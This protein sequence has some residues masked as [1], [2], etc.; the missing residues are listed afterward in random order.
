MAGTNYQHLY[1]VDARHDDIRDNKNKL[2]LV[3]VAT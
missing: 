3:A 1:H 2:F